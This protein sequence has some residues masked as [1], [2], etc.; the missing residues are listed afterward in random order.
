MSHW[1]RTESPPPTL[2]QAEKGTDD[3]LFKKLKTVF[4]QLP[5][6][7]S[8]DSSPATQNNSSQNQEDEEEEEKQQIRLSKLQQTQ[9]IN[10]IRTWELPSQDHELIHQRTSH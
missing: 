3:K 9:T 1:S 10:P 8:Q 5:A 2:Q 7:T 6:R 4:S